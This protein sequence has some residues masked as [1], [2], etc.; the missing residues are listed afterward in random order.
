M[1]PA[2]LGAVAAVATI[3]A[4]QAS[5]QWML[6]RL[7]VEGS[8]GRGRVETVAENLN[9]VVVW[10]RGVSF[11]LFADDASVMR[12]A[13]IAV[14]LAVSVGLAVWLRRARY[15]LLGLALGLVIGGAIGNVIDRVRHGAVFDFLDFHLA[16][17]H[18]PAFNVA[19]A[20]ISVGVVVLLLDGLFGRRE[21]HT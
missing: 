9:L 7:A 13:L 5:K 20:G 21:G 11:G 6:G 18:W 1:S 17:Y 19:D 4:D 12:W 15:G 16:G 10:N 2:A 14:A 8:L 3:A